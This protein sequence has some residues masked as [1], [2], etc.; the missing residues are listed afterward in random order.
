MRF[1]ILSSSET[2]KQNRWFHSK[3]KQKYLLTEKMKLFCAK[4]I[5]SHAD[6]VAGEIQDDPTDFRWNFIQYKTYVN[7][8]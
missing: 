1:S 4:H 2:Q 6:E 5:R 7:V 3:K 8:N